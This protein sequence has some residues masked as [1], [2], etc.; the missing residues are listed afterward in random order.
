MKDFLKVMKAC[1]DPNRVKIVKMLALKEMCVC[2]LTSAL[3]LAQPTVSSHLKVLEEAGLVRS[4]KDGLWV[5]YQLAAPEG[6]PY[7]ASLLA[8]LKGWLNQDPEITSL[9][10]RLP[11]IRREEI[12]KK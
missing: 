4:R 9:L 10:T 7:A 5:N 2:E 1:S 8:G 3:N 12:C 6:N 11:Q